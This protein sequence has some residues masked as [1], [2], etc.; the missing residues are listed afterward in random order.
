MQPPQVPGS[1]PVP[2]PV[3]VVC[4]RSAPTTLR[5]GCC[6]SCCSAL[7]K[8]AKQTDSTV[9]DN[10]CCVVRR[11]GVATSFKPLFGDRHTWHASSHTLS[12]PKVGGCA[13]RAPVHTSWLTSA[14]VAAAAVVPARAP[15]TAVSWRGLLASPAAAA[16]SSSVAAVLL[17][18]RRWV[19]SSSYSLLVLLRGGGVA[20]CSCE[21]SRCRCCR[22]AVLMAAS[23][24]APAATWQHVGCCLASPRL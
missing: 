17:V 8:R 16:V 15:A 3:P 18:L 13:G 9:L 24:A 1:I 6:C 12:P 21:P 19:L 2:I 4:Q 7:T 22:P 10:S 14:A 20:S 5:W 11:G 23:V